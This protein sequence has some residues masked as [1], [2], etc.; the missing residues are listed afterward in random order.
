MIRNKI[1]QNPEIAKDEPA[2]VTRHAGRTDEKI[3]IK[4]VLEIQLKVQ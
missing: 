4:Q 1:R 2:K 3:N